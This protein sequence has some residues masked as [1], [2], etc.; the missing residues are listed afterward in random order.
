MSGLKIEGVYRRCGL[1][2]KVHELVK[3]LTVSPKSAPL[4]HDEQGVLD[5]ASALKLYIR[6]QESLIPDTERQQ[7]LHAAG[8]H[9]YSRYAQTHTRADNQSC[10]S[11][12]SSSTSVISVYHR[13]NMQ[14]WNVSVAPAVNL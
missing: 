1:V 8:E 13:D 12:L 4:E 6:Q 9:K 7:W 5:T 11:A 14:L 10:S 2:A 3:I